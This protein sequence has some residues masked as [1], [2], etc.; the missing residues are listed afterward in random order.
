MEDNIIQNVPDPNHEKDIM[1]QTQTFTQVYKELGWSSH[2]KESVSGTGSIL[3]NTEMLREQL[4]KICK[5]YNINKIVDI[6]CGDFNWMKEIVHNFE[7]YRGVDIVEDL[8]ISNKEKYDDLDNVEFLTADVIDDF[9]KCISGESFDAIILKD[10]F[11]HF[12][13]EYVKKVLASIGNSSIKYVFIT[14]FNSIQSNYDIEEFNGW[15]P[16]NF[17]ISPWRIGNPIESIPSPTEK[18]AWDGHAYTDKTL[19]L[20]K[21]T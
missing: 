17:T 3:K 12:P 20:W 13:N 4:P 2:Q 19:S 6:A 9:N 14:H 5:A 7:F 21:I 16:Q 15:R 1:D 18:Y 11:V 10:V 8:I